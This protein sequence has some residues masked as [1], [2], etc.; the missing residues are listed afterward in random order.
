MIL[1]IKRMKSHDFDQH[2]IMYMCVLTYACYNVL[3]CSKWRGIN[4][5]YNYNAAVLQGRL[6]K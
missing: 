1:I 6:E 3:W 4:N 2:A 5:N